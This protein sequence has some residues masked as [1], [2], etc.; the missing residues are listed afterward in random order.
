MKKMIAWLMIM[1]SAIGFCSAHADER[2]DC[3]L[4]EN[5]Y[6]DAEIP[7]ITRE[8]IAVYSA[9]MRAPSIEEFAEMLMKE[10]RGN[11]RIDVGEYK[12]TLTGEYER[13]TAPTLSNESISVYDLL[14]ENEKEYEK[15]SW[16]DQPQFRE[17]AGLSEEHRDLA[18]MSEE[19]VIG[20]CSEM[21]KRL[22]MGFTP[23]CSYVYSYTADDLNTVRD[24][25]Y[26]NDGMYHSFYD[27]GKIPAV[28]KFQPED[29]IYALHFVF[30][31]DNIV[32]YNNSDHLGLRSLSEDGL[33]AAF[34]MDADITLNRDG[35]IYF[36]LSNC[37]G[38][39]GDTNMERI[40]DV[41]KA[42]ELAAGIF[43]DVILTSPVLFNQVYL[44]YL[45]L[46]GEGTSITMRPVWRFCRTAAD[47][48]Q[49]I[50][51]DMYRID[52]VTGE[53]IR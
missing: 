20:L 42:A 33:P 4:A 37:I 1:F 48:P 34:R 2:L 3:K 13:M 39:T 9:E 47:D 10:E 22:N 51:T 28:D 29:E 27:S 23:Q 46:K 11:W 26:K 25:L 35:I 40:I 18:F 16:L 30:S 52:A 45:P 31:L 14:Y 24:W 19:E 36:H 6:I 8:D 44:E 53:V 7:N 38:L 41:H 17:D 21:L 5:V 49:M 50:I 15:Y 12:T 43:D 32:V